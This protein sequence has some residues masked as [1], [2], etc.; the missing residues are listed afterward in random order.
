[1]PESALASLSIVL[2]QSRDAFDGKH[3]V[4]AGPIGS[5]QSAWRTDICGRNRLEASPRWSR[6]SK[7]GVLIAGS[8]GFCMT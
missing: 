1:M 3:A 2:D 8:I 6:K 5:N 4:I 7:H